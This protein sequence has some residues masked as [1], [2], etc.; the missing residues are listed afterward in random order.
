MN[1]PLNLQRFLEWFYYL[2]L[3]E[4]V[5]EWDGISRLLLRIDLL[6]LLV[7]ETAGDFCSLVDVE[8][9]SGQLRHDSLRLP[10]RLPTGPWSHSVVAHS[11]DFARRVAAVLP[12]GF[13]LVGLACFLMKDYIIEDFWLLWLEQQLANLHGPKR[14]I[15][16]R[17]CCLI[18]LLYW[19]F[20]KAFGPCLL[21]LNL[22]ILYDYWHLQLYDTVRCRLRR[23]PLL[24]EI[25]L[26]RLTYA[27]PILRILWVLLLLKWTVD[28][29]L[30]ALLVFVVAAVSKVALLVF[31]I[32]ADILAGANIC[33]AVHGL[34]ALS[35]L[36][37]SA[38]QGW[39]DRYRRRLVHLCLWFQ[40]LIAAASRFD[41]VQMRRRRPAHYCCWGGCI[42]SGQKVLQML[43]LI[44][45]LNHRF[46]E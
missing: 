31:R 29:I 3:Q 18:F 12:L 34:P 17:R 20:C 5:G 24:I 10:L 16:K 28:A 35:Y 40:S 2:G 45:K 7:E 13:A 15:F 9:A 37:V 11:E 23:R 26:L 46:R 36:H 27:H 1:L 14:L 22:I 39:Q 4:V 42:Q 44:R 32:L 6:S 19:G 30:F 21:L 8:A 41:R 43:I 25:R 38:F 33:S